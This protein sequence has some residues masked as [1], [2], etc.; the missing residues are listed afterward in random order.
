MP[1]A[2][3]VFRPF[4]H[5]AIAEVHDDHEVANGSGLI[6]GLARRG[7]VGSVSPV[8][9]EANPPRPTNRR[10]TS[11]GALLGVTVGSGPDR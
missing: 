3:R 8:G 6:P 10:P 11:T 7:C 1:D 5:K 9:T 2:G 4:P